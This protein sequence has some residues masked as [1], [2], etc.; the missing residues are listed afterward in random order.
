MQETGGRFARYEL[1]ELLGEGAMARVFK[2]Y[3]PRT[4]RHVAVKIL[5]DSCSSDRGFVD[6]F[7]REARAAGA[8]SHHNI[9]RINSVDEVPAPYIDMELVEGPSLAQLLREQGRLP[10]RQAAQIVRDLALALQDAHGRGRVHRDIKPSNILLAADRCTPKLADFGIAMIAQPEAT[11][12]TQHGQMLGTPRYMSPEQIRGDPTDARSDLFSLGVTFYEMVTGTYAFRGDSLVTLATQILQSD[13]RPV[14]EIAPD[15]PRRIAAVIDRLLAKNPA[16]RI[17]S[18]AE[19][20]ATLE[21]AA[22]PSPRSKEARSRPGRP[23]AGAGGGPPSLWPRLLGAAALVALVAGIAVLFFWPHNQSPLAIDDLADTVAGQPVRVAVLANDRDLDEGDHIR[24]VAAEL[25]GGAP[26]RVEI[27]GDALLYDPGEAFAPLASGET[28]AVSIAYTIE[29]SHGVPASAFAHVTVRGAPPT[30]PNQPP[31]AVDDTIEMRAD[32]RALIDLLANDRDPDPGDQL[33]LASASLMQGAPGRL[34]VTGNI[35]E[36]DPDG[37]FADLAAGARQTV[38]IRYTVR[39]QAGLSADGRAVVNV[40]GTAQA[41]APVPSP[42]LSP[43]PPSP[44]TPPTIPQESIPRIPQETP[45]VNAQEAWFR[46]AADVMSLPC[47]R[48]EAEPGRPKVSLH[49]AVADA[50]MRARLL[51]RIKTIPGV[52]VNRIDLIDQ[53]SVLCRA[54]DLLSRHTLVAPRRLV[55]LDRPIAEVCADSRCYSG[56]AEYR[57]VDGERLVL[58]LTMPNFP[59][60]P[61][62]DYL[63]ADGNVLHLWPRPTGEPEVVTAEAYSEAQ[64]PEQKI[65]IGDLRAGLGSPSYT[66][67]APFGRELIMVVAARSPLFRTARPAVEPAAAYLDALE[68]SL[69]AAQ[70]PSRPLASAMPLETLAR[71]P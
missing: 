42:S 4:D 7:L 32:Q 41:L 51:E 31:L 60:Y 55:R 23:S 44:P 71:L 28:A 30:L 27:V 26:G 34:T 13:P 54:F 37:A 64:P 52:T 35:V 9:V 39:D 46:L 61:T 49:G 47:T 53:T 14:R 8:L 65:A 24:L 48:L 12:L 58:D 66:I 11:Q 5:K 3:D 17:Q 1:L 18:A 70:S 45:P 50:T 68:M 20:A 43:A 25:T 16:G 38:E 57:L 63:M 33:E 69:A 21:S 40:T 59:N 29:D 15:V 67:G 62:I 36:Y 19:L 6:R 22:D 56:L 2:A 10:G